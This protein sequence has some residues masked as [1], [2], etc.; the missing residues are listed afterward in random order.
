MKK[1]SS[2]IYVGLVMLFLYLP[3]FVLILYSFNDGKTSVWKG[4]TLKWYSELFHSTAI[5]SSLY[6]TLIIAVARFP[7]CDGARHGGGNRPL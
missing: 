2:K 5:M 1:L 3:I 7:R 6:N 4:F